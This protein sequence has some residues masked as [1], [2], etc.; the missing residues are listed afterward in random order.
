MHSTSKGMMLVQYGKTKHTDFLA[1]REHATNVSTIGR[2]P[3][4]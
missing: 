3:A 2:E 1:S 4:T